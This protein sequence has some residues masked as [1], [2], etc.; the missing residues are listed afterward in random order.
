MNPWEITSWVGAIAVTLVI[1][2]LTVSV[3]RGAF[4]RSRQT[5]ARKRG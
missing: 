4:T 5:A 2:V 3:V 1:V